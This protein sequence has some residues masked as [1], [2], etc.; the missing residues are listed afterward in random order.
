MTEDGPAQ[1]GHKQ[2]CRGQLKRK[3]GLAIDDDEIGGAGVTQNL[4]HAVY[5]P[6]RPFDAG[7][8]APSFRKTLK[9]GE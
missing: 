9:I 7:R 4:K 5:F 1:K 8:R 3:I 6:R 2:I